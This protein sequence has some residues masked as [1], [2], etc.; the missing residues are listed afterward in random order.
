MEGVAR[1]KGRCSWILLLPWKS[2]PLDV[3]AFLAGFVHSRAQRTDL[4]L[5]RA[6]WFLKKGVSPLAFSP[7]LSLHLW[8]PPP[9]GFA[10]CV[11]ALPAC[12]PKSMQSVIIRVFISKSSAG[13]T[14]SDTVLIFNMERARECYHPL[15][16]YVIHSSKA[17]IFF[18]GKKKKSWCNS[19]SLWASVHKQSITYHG[20]TTYYMACDAAYC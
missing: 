19:E 5:P 8:N 11:S 13:E 10:T 7:N 14:V 15:C 9:Q 12:P 2:W 4:Q 1:A 17:K 20:R 6:V 16:Q 3:L 18:L